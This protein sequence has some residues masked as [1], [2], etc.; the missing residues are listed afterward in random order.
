MRKKILSWIFVAGVLL[1]SV[2][3]VAG[4]LFAGPAQAG[5]NEVLAKAPQLKNK[6]GKLNDHF[7]GDTA[8]WVNDHFFG[9]QELISTHNKTVSTVFGTSAA[10]DVILGNNG[11]LYYTSTLNDYTGQ[12]TLDHQQITQAANNLALMQE[13]CQSQGREF[14]F[15]IAPNKN[16][17]YPENMPDYG[18]QNPATNAKRLMAELDNRAV[19]YIDL[20]AVFGQEAEVLYFAHDSHWDSKGAALGADSI[21]DVFGVQSDYFGGD[22]SQRAP[23]EG[24]LYDMLYPSFTDPE[25]DRLFGGDLNFT[26][27]GK[28]T[29]PDSITLETESEA[30]GSLLCY[31][32]S[33]GNL[34]YPYLADSYGTCRFSRSVNYDLT[35]AGESVLIEL[36]ER[37]IGY[38]CTNLPVM[39]APERT[40]PALPKPADT[41]VIESKSVKSPEGMFRVTGTLPEMADTDSPVYVICG[42]TAYEA[43]QLQDGGFGAYTPAEAEGIAFYTGGI[44]HYYYNAQ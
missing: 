33:F 15:M 24:D 42:N 29:K 37:N 30:P 34:L 44:L 35:Q 20:F 16:S 18:V 17:L 39:P 31:R 43:F 22:F 41:T 14:A 3:L 2:T 21:N 4:I 7:L 19:A 12:Q 26:Y 40:L 38:L 13:Y 1:M 11:W 6:D 25:Q 27:T 23:H 32:D 9:R 36:V 5:A 8:A 28:A 10:D